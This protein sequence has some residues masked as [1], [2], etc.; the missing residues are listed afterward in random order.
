M[1]KIVVIIIIIILTAENS[2]SSRFMNPSF[3]SAQSHPAS[4]HPTTSGVP[5][6]VREHIKALEDELEAHR[7]TVGQLRNAVAEFLTDYS[8]NAHRIPI[9]EGGD[10]PLIAIVR[11]LVTSLFDQKRR[12]VDENREAQSIARAKTEI[13]ANMSHEIRT[14]MHGIFGMVNLVLDTKLESDQREYVE[15]IRSSTESLLTILND[16]LDY[17]KLSSSQV[18]L[19]PRRFSTENLLRDVLRT[20]SANASKK[21]IEL[22]TRIGQGVPEE[23]I[24]DDHRLRQ[25]L[26][27]LAGNAIKFTAE[28][29]VRIEIEQA[30][31]ERDGWLTLQFKVTDTG[32]GIPPERVGHLFQPFTQAEVSTSRQ[33]GGTGLGL[34]ISRNLVELMGGRIWVESEVGRGSVFHF[35]TRLQIASPSTISKESVE[36]DPPTA[37]ISPFVDAHQ[38]SAAKPRP[39]REVSGKDGNGSK[40]TRAERTHRVLLVEDNDVNQKV[41][42]LTLEKFGYTVDIASNGIQAI[43]LAKVNHY[44][45]IC[46]D[47]QMPEMDGIEA[48]RHIRNLETASARSKIIAMTGHAFAAHRNHCLQSGMDAFITKPFDLIE[49]KT[50]LDRLLGLLPDSQADTAPADDDNNNNTRDPVALSA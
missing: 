20:F 25:V 12:L 13:L 8:D 26:S 22:A 36:A 11:S 42:Q 32:P 21:G 39:A 37:G 27:N 24:G 35:T 38:R 45:V 16:V 7:A 6:A 14:P 18:S 4:S 46:M 41:G 30:D 49:L 1:L 10:D 33:F 28:G 29:S 40:P 3:A 43:E 50:T 15:T 31:P 47:V 2:V 23:L 34:T 9:L 5:A 48:T 44:Q 17:S 19:E